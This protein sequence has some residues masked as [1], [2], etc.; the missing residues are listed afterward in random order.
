MTSR[1]Q[2]RLDGK[3]VRCGGVRDVPTRLHCQSCLLKNRRKL[4]LFFA[5]GRGAQYRREGR[6]LTCG[7]V[8]ADP[9]RRR[10]PSCLANSRARVAKWQLARGKEI[11]E[12]RRH[13]EA[14]MTCGDTLDPRSKAMCRHHLAAARRSKRNR[15]RKLFGAG[16][17]VECKKSRETRNFALC[18]ACRARHRAQ[19]QARK[20]T[21]SLA[22]QPGRGIGRHGPA[23]RVAL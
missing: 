17:C 22:G 19:Y 14:C 23:S 2:F 18:D 5:S 16:Q 9:T 7:C 10:C 12:L 6:C 15:W 21:R 11:A 8:K 20:D 3:C 4:A 13:F 1:E